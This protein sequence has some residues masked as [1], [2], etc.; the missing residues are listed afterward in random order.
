MEVLRI[1]KYST[2][3][4]HLVQTLEP[5]S[6]LSFQ[7]PA[8]LDSILPN[9]QTEKSKES[10]NEIQLPPNSIVYLGLHTQQTKAKR[11]T[12]GTHP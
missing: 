7:A 10:R 5:A 11:G 9:N 4:C 12:I 8:T 1:I 2:Y 6:P 3:T